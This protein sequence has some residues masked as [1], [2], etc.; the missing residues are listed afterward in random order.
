VRSAEIDA[1]ANDRSTIDSYESVEEVTSYEAGVHRV[2]DRVEKQSDQVR[3]RHHTPEVEHVSI[4]PVSSLPLVPD[5]FATSA[6]S[7]IEE[8]EAYSNDMQQQIDRAN[9]L[10]DLIGPSLEDLLPVV[11]GSS[12]QGNSSIVANS[13]Q[14]MQRFIKPDSPERTMNR[15]V[16]RS[17]SGL[18]SSTGKEYGLGDHSL[19]YYS[20]IY[21][22]NLKLTKSSA[23]L[24]KKT[25]IHR[26]SCM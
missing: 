19:G 15:H 12:S 8:D 6:R 17:L 13:A 23:V 20:G 24:P 2:Y 5:D 21:V 1:V 26:F 9:A 4:E 18:I 14:R 25:V 3:R 16:A 11:M 7:I 10:Q 22:T